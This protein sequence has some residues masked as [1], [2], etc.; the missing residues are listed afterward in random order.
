M[1][2]L[3]LTYSPPYIL[4]CDECDNEAKV[5]SLVSR[6]QY[7]GRHCLTLGIERHLRSMARMAGEVS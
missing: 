3:L 1:T 7:C 4:R 6:G 2:K 5:I